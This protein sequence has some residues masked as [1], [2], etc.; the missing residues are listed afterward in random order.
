MRN[1]IL[2]WL[3]KAAQLPAGEE[4]YLPVETKPEQK[5]L[6]RQYTSEIQVLK[7]IDAVTG[8]QLHVAP[9]YK[10]G[11]LWIVLRKLATSPVVGFQKNTLTGEIQ[12]VSV[13]DDAA[14]IRRIRLMFEDGM[15]QEDIEAIEG[16]LTHDEL[17]QF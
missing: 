16:S 12:R 17:K 10:D 4:I 14:R 9:V 2:Q 7:Q 3:H 5:S 15:K 1:V 11:K 6:I 13:V 8:S